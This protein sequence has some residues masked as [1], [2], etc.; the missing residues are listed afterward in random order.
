MVE[1]DSNRPTDS[2]HS[3]LDYD[4]DEA[5]YISYQMA[6]LLLKPEIEDW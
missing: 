2:S 4:Q 3:A 1:L 6:H 5:W